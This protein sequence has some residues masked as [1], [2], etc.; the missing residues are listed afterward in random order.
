MMINSVLHASL[1]AE[2]ARYLTNRSG[3][4]SGLSLQRLHGKEISRRAGIVARAL[5]AITAARVS[6]FLLTPL[7][8]GK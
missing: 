2:N 8:A 1:R 3:T 5:V 6:R 4:A 7:P